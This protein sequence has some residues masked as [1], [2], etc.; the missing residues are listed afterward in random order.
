MKDIP[1]KPMRYQREGTIPI[2]DLG[3]L[4]YVE[5]NLERDEDMEEEDSYVDD[6]GV[7]HFFDTWWKYELEEDDE[8]T[9]LVECNS[10]WRF[11]I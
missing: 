1:L 9:R 11:L 6:V 3:P 7:I 4:V 10:I 8:V 2:E 5:P